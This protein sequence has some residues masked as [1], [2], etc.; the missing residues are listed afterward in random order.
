MTWFLDFLWPILIKRILFLRHLLFV[1]I[2]LILFVAPATVFPCSTSV[3]YFN[4]G[5][6]FCG[7]SSNYPYY[8]LYCQ[9]GYGGNTTIGAEYLVKLRASTLSTYVGSSLTSVAATINNYSLSNIVVNIY[10]QGSSSSSPGS[11]IY[12]AYIGAQTG[13]V[14]HTLSSTIDVQNRDLWIGFYIAWNGLAYPMAYNSSTVYG[15]ND[16]DG[17]YINWCWYN[18]SSTQCSFSSVSG[19][20]NWAIKAYLTA[21]DPVAANAGPDT[22]HIGLGTISLQGN[23][24]AD[25]A[26]QTWSIVSGGGGTIADAHSA[27][28]GFTPSTYGTVGLYWTRQKLF[29]SSNDYVTHTFVKADQTINFDALPNKTYG[30]P[31]FEVSAT[32]SSNPPVSFSSLTNSVCSVSGTTVSLLSAGT[33]SLRVSQAGNADFNPAPNV[34]QSFTVQR[35]TPTLSLSSTPTSDTLPGQSVT[36]TATV[37]ATPPGSGTPSGTVTFNDGASTLCTNVILSSGSAA[38]ATGALSL[39]SHSLTAVYSGDTNFTGGTS[40]PLTHNVNQAPAIT[41][42]ATATFTV[43][44]ASSFTATATGTPAPTL[45]YSGAL[46]SGVSFTNGTLSGTPAAGT[47]TTYPLVLTASNGIGSA[48]TQNF[49]LTVQGSDN[50]LDGYRTPDDCNDNDADIHPGATEICD[51]QDNDCDPTTVEHCPLGC[52]QP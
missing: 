20:T 48:A 51:R 25:G 15:L 7:Y 3:D 31:S 1:T 46:P 49:T 19:V 10:D 47:E 32:A 27:T 41:S 29:C 44:Q 28:S 11:R 4:G 33:C 6:F 21:P 23:S 24:A 38:C 12:Q 42:A 5:G 17:H 35:A 37:A 18:G 2:P 8:P 50:D 43:G 26:T 52:P 9:S 34:D 14:T 40:A 45:S 30:D 39:G 36:F 16:P 13:Y 22:T